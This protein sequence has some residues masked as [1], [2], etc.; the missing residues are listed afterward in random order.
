M[1][2]RESTRCLKTMWGKTQGKFSETP[3]TGRVAPATKCMRSGETVQNR[4]R[5]RYSQLN[6]WRKRMKRR[7]G[8]T[9]ATKVENTH[10]AGGRLPFAIPHEIVP[11]FV[12]IQRDI[13]I[14]SRCLK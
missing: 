4:I 8:A 7:E 1:R 12:P 13:S 9:R 14:P 3:R 10:L 2:L 11:S 5:T 6:F